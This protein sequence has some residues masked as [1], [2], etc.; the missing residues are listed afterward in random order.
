MGDGALGQAGGPSPRL[1][2]SQ[3]VRPSVLDCHPR[4]H[5]QSTPINLA[6]PPIKVAFVWNAAE[7]LKC[8][9]WRKG[10]CF[11]DPFAVNL[12]KAK[13]TAAG[14]PCSPGFNISSP[15]PSSPRTQGTL[16]SPQFNN[17]SIWIVF[18]SRSCGFKRNT[19]SIA[20]D[21]A[22]QPQLYF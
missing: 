10:G 12:V 14:E 15:L 8:I 5:G 20:L 2:L 7:G 3:A 11:V 19:C 16:S 13:D 22:Q 18:Q 9:P 4:G 17:A 6:A 21:A 1:Q